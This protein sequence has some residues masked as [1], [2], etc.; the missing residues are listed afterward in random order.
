M[1]ENIRSWWNIRDLPNVKLIHFN[2]MKADLPGP[3]REIG[4]FLGIKPDAA[5]FPKIAEHCTFDYMKANAEKAAP[6]GGTLWSDGAKTFIN[7]GTNG[8]WRD[9]LSAAEIA[10]YEARAL[11]EL[12]PACSKWLAQGNAK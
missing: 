12:G 7:K 2:D 10:T 4:D 6:L 8:R 1:W 3:I 9:T 5:T 11:N